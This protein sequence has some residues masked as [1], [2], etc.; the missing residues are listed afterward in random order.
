MSFHVCDS[1]V[2]TRSQHQ[3]WIC[4]GTIPPKTPAIGHQLQLGGDDGVERLW[5]HPP[6]LAVAEG[7]AHANGWDHT[8]WETTQMATNDLHEGVDALCRGL[9]SLIGLP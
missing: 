2:T 5:W 8:E 6:C 4:G 1:V 9:R 7:W 3:C